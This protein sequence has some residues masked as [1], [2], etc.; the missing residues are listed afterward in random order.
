MSDFSPWQQFGG[1]DHTLPLDV[2]DVVD[3][4]WRILSGESPWNSMTLDDRWGAMRPLVAELVNEARDPDDDRRTRRLAALALEHGAFRAAQRCRRSG[5]VC[6][7]GIILDALDH[8]LRQLGA[9]PSLIL[10]AMAGF[11]P[12]VEMAQRT[13]LKGWQRVTTHRLGAQALAVQRLL[14]EVG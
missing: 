7:F 5:V 8:A 10:D 9:P 12:E 2:D 1:W 14:D 6:E 4:W 3:R 11:D 13:A